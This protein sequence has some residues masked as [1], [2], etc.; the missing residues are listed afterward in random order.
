MEAGLIFTWY[1]FSRN[2]ENFSLFSC[3]HS[4]PCGAL[5]RTQPRSAVKPW[6][7]PNPQNSCPEGPALQPHLLHVGEFSEEDVVPQE[8][9]QL[10]QLAQVLHVV[11]PDFLPVKE[12]VV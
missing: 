7:A 9:P 2:W 6:G 1:S 10:R 12:E 11:F 3:G 8:V 4:A 5:P